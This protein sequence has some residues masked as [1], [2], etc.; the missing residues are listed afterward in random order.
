MRTG[1]TWIMAAALPLLLSCG[2]SDHGEAGPAAVSALPDAYETC[3]SDLEVSLGRAALYP[4]AA[5]DVVRLDEDGA[6]IVVDGS[7]SGGD[8]VTAVLL[9]TVNCMLESAEAPPT[10]EQALQT[11]TP[12]MG[13]QSE[14]WDGYTLDWTVS[15]G[16]AAL[17]GGTPWLEL[18][19]VLSYETD[20]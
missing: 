20:R 17:A 2:A 11:S 7:D 16:Q 1:A 14:S 18:S 19:A 15:T 3:T 12:A 13:R 4:P 5:T 6:S 9:Q 10:V 8:S